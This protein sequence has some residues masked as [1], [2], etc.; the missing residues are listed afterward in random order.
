MSQRAV[1][2]SATFD[3]GA[4]LAT[5]ERLLEDAIAIRRGEPSPGPG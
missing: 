2:R 4:H 5:I 1:E 3:L